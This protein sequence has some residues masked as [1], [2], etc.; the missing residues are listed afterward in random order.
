MCHADADD[1]RGD[2]GVQSQQDRR[3]GDQDM[4]DGAAR[5]RQTVVGVVGY[6]F[7]WMRRSVERQRNV[8]VTV[9]PIVRVSLGGAC[10]F[11]A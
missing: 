4:G 1:G 2:D 7:G 3:L 8:R 10:S 6:P 5:R 11:L 9:C